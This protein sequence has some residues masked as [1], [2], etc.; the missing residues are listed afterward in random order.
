[1]PQD[2]SQFADVLID[3]TITVEADT[4]RGNEEGAD[5][6]DRRLWLEIEFWYGNRPFVGEDR[7]FVEALIDTLNYLMLV[8]YPDAII[9]HLGC[10]RCSPRNHYGD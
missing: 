4:A 3:T 6:L 7:G 8:C 9:R 5:F 10:E 2:V 1:M